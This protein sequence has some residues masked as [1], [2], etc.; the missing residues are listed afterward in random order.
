MIVDCQ[1]QSEE[2]QATRGKMECL[3]MMLQER[4]N[5]RQARKDRRSC[6][7]PPINCHP[8]SVDSSSQDGST[9]F[10]FDTDMDAAANM[11]DAGAHGFA[12]IMQ[13]NEAELTQGAVVV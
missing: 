5:R 8:L 12:Q 1:R 9:S 3:Q 7:Y 4:R 11:A 2:N 6:P 10:G 13:E